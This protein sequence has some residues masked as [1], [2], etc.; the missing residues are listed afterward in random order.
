MAPVEETARVVELE[1]EMNAL[2]INKHDLQEREKHLNEEILKNALKMEELDLKTQLTK[3]KTREKM[4]AGRRKRTEGK[5][6]L[7]IKSEQLDSIKDI[8]ST[9]S[10]RNAPMSKQMDYDIIDKQ[11]E[12][13]G[14]RTSA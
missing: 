5:A 12:I 8:E 11:N 7:E 13:L 14:A 4:F 1:A 2:K 6:G 9:H 10:L 3:A